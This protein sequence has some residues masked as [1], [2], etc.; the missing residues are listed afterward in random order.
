ML[1]LPWRKKPALN[2]SLTWALF[3]KLWCLPLTSTRFVSAVEKMAS[4][5]GQ[6]L[7]IP[8]YFCVVYDYAGKANPSKGYWNPK[9]KLGEG[10]G[11]P[12]IFLEIIKKQLFKKKKTGKYKAMYDDFFPNWSFIISEKCIVSPSFLFGYQDD[13]V[14]SAFSA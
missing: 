8:K 4:C 2:L 1:L 9:R 3:W 11:E 5:Y 13:V 12:H 6:C 14:I 10:G 7:L